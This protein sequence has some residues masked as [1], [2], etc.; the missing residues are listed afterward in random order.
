M[1]CEICEK[2]VQTMYLEKPLGTVVKDEKGKR[3]WLCNVCQ[4]KFQSKEQALAN[5]K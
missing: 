1:K 3:H 2:Q 4:S 5:I